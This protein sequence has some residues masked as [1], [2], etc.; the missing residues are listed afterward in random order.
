[1][2]RH[3]I[4]Q[5]TCTRNCLIQ[6]PFV[7]WVRYQA[8]RRDTLGDAGEL[9]RRSYSGPG[10]WHRATVHGSKRCPQGYFLGGHS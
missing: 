8:E 9:R 10:D 1:M 7:N 3:F 5:H 2:A 4:V 6:C